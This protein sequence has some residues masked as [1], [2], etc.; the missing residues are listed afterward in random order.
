MSAHKELQIEEVL[1]VFDQKLTISVVQHAKKQKKIS[2]TLYY[3][4]V[5][6]DKFSSV[7]VL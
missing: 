6:N 4:C 1:S 7:L 5:L 2:D 3:V